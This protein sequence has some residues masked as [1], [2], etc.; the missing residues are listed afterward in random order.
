M[1]SRQPVQR[2]EREEGQIVAMVVDKHLAPQGLYFGRLLS[3]AHPRLPRYMLRD[4]YTVQS[5][6]GN[7]W[8]E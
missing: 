3:L 7:E 2:C 4:E 1:A 8:Q 5:G 6:Y